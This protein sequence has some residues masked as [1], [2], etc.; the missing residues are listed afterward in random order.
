MAAAGALLLASLLLPWYEAGAPAHQFSGWRMLTVVDVWLAATA[1]LGV[2]ALAASTA[3]ATDAAAIALTAL[4]GLAGVVAALLA[5]LRILD[6]PGDL[7]VAPSASVAPGAWLGLGAAVG[8]AVATIT[9]MRDERQR[10]PVADPMIEVR[11]A[12]APGPGGGGA[13]TEN[14]ER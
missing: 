7:Q 6:L 9:A 10:G 1:L 8:L 11:R 2:A 5:L 12:P 13:P 3:P 4:A 14:R